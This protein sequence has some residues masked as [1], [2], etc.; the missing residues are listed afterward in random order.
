[1]REEKAAK[2]C[3]PG[4]QPSVQAAAAA[5][6]LWSIAPARLLPA[7]AL[8]WLFVGLSHLIFPPAVARQNGGEL[9]VPSAWLMLVSEG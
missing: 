5:G 6:R 4:V 2:S 3:A 8:L 1:M 9:S 7:R